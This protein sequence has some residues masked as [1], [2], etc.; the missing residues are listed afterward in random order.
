MFKDSTGNTTDSQASS[1]GCEILPSIAALLLRLLLLIV[2]RATVI[3][4]H[5][6]RALGRRIVSTL[7]LGRRNAA[8]TIIVPRV[9]GLLV[10]RLP[11][12]ATSGLFYEECATGTGLPFLDPALWQGRRG[13]WRGTG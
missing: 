5:R 10:R 7:R 2:A 13:T 8:R 6:W 3:V 1:T 9:C 11:L 12:G 4:G